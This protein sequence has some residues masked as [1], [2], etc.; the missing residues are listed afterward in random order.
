MTPV[1]SR[2]NPNPDNGAPAT[3]KKASGEDHG[4]E[5]ISGQQRDG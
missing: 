4:L 5:G 2:D 3:A 1:S